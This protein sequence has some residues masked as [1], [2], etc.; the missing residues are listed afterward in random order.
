[1]LMKSKKLETLA[2]APYAG[3]PLVGNHA[4]EFS[5]RFGAYRIVYEMDRAS[6]MVSLLIIKHTRHVYQQ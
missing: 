3:K 6:H 2:G 1:M 4:G 5:L